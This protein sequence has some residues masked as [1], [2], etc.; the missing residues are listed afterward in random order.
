MNRQFNIGVPFGTFS[1]NGHII[2][3][4]KCVY[5][6][7][8]LSSVESRLLGA[9]GALEISFV[10]KGAGVV[11]LLFRFEYKT[12]VI[13]R[14]VNTQNVKIARRDRPHILASHRCETFENFLHIDVAPVRRTLSGILHSK[15]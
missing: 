10:V 15:Y 5:N 1:L 7:N 8:T 12:S 2:R 9:H 4:H 6:K 13:C 14:N 11:M 3:F